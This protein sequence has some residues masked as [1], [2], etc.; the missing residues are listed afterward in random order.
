MRQERFTLRE[1]ELCIFAVLAEYDVPFVH[2]AHS[3]IGIWAGFSEEQVQQA[4][5]GKLPDDLDP[6]ESAIFTLAATLAKLR[7]PLS[8]RDFEQASEA[9]RRDEVVGVAHIVS[10]YIY[11]AMLSNIGGAGVPSMKEGIFQATKNPKFPENE[12]VET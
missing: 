7:G 3:Q 8:D 6:R 2:Y 9:L 10:G 4:V 5:H 12:V 11:V 1:K